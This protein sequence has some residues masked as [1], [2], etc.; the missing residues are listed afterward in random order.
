[1]NSGIFYL[2]FFLIYSVIISVIGIKL[3][4]KQKTGE[5]Y[6]LAGRSLPILVVFGTALATLIGTGSSMGATSIAY[7]SGFAALAFSFYQI[8]NMLILAFVFSKMRDYKINTVAE[9]MAMYYGANETVQGISAIMLMLAEVGWSAV[10][11][12]GGGTYLA[13][14]TGINFRLAIVIAAVVFTILGLV[15]GYKSVAITDTLQVFIMFFGFIILA[16]VSF[17][18]AGGWSNIQANVPSSFFSFLG[19]EETGWVYLIFFVFQGLLPSF[20]MPVYR[21]RIYSAKSTQAAKKSYI[22]CAVTYAVFMFLPVIIGISARV[23]NPSLDNADSTFPYLVTTQLPLLLAAVVM[24]AGL[25]ATATSADSDLMVATSI[26]ITDI[27]RFIFKKPCPQ[28]KMVQY[29]RYANLAITLLALLSTLFAKNLVDLIVKI[30]GFIF[31][32]L[33]VS[34]VL[35]MTWKRSTWQGAV[36]AIL[37]GPIVS[38]IVS[39]IPSV[40]ELFKGIAAVPA[41][42]VAIIIHVA[43]SLCTPENTMSVEEAVKVLVARRGDE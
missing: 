6:L 39:N 10:H 22:L 1:M 31:S 24:S 12:F 37:S 43:V 5:D 17:Q 11:M 27:W 9:E 16:A 30:A 4:G 38:L 33:T 28:E 21:Q 15:G 34:M 40:L 13:A 7:K 32:G 23:L 42:I 3:S 14:I 8:I 29:S 25:S 20:C 26:V 35:G 2:V 19:V 36:C 41:V 18:H